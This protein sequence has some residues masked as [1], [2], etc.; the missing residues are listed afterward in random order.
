MVRESLF[1]GPLMYR[2]I[3]LSDLLRGS[4]VMVVLEVGKV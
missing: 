1:E 4:W 2:V 3:H